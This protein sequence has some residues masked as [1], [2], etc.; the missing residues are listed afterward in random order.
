[1]STGRILD[2]VYDVFDVEPMLLTGPSKRRAYAHARHA[3]VSLLQRHTALSLEHIGE[4]LERHHTT[5]LA[6]ER[7]CKALAARSEQF[8]EKLAA[9]EA[10]LRGQA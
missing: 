10:R 8:R 1:M 4:L 2:A 7:R 3:A 9:C 6:S 5:I